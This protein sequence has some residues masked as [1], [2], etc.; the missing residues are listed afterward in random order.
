MAIGKIIGIIMILFS[1][2]VILKKYF[3]YALGV[4][5]GLLIIFFII[6]YLADLYWWGKDND[7]W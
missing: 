3:F 6:R 2:M 5:I 4:I 7:K 1:L